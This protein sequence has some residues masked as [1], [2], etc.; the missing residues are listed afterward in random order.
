MSLPYLST[1]MLPSLLSLHNQLWVFFIIVMHIYITFIVLLCLTHAWLESNHLYLP[2][3]IYILY[4]R[5]VHGRA[6]SLIS[7]SCSMSYII[8]ILYAKGSKLGILYYCPL[9][10]SSVL[11]ALQNWKKMW[12]AIS[13]NPLTPLYPLL[14]QSSSIAP[15]PVQW[16]NSEA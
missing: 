3:Y 5:D 14:R 13:W 1:I 15:F 8:Y 12:M 2:I 16:L 10:S 7:S 4:I 9:Y 6:F 11:S